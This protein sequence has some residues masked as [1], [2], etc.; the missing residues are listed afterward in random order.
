MVLAMYGVL[1]RV[2]LIVCTYSMYDNDDDDVLAHN[3]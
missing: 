3:Y 2:C 1:V